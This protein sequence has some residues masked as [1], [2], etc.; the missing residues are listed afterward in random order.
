MGIDQRI[1]FAIDSEPRQRLDHDVAFPGAVVFA[2]PMLDRAPPA[3]A[4]MRTERR[5]PLRARGLDLQQAPAVGVTRHRRHFDGL[6][7]QRIRHIDRHSA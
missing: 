7:G 4:E 3:D 2:F 6:A 5:D 1:H